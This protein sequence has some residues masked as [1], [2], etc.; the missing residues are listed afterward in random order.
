MNMSQVA[1]LSGEPI[2]EFWCIATT[3]GMGS[4]S[5]FEYGVANYLRQVSS[6]TSWIGAMSMTPK[7]SRSNV[8]S[9][10]PTSPHSFR[11]TLDTWFHAKLLWQR[12]AVCKIH[13][14]IWQNDG[15]WI[16]SLQTWTCH[17]WQNMLGICRISWPHEAFPRLRRRR[18]RSLLWSLQNTVG[19]APLRADT[20]LC[21]RTASLKCFR[22][23]QSKW[24]RGRHRWQWRFP[25]S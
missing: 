14:Q 4:G 8:E 16:G 15:I 18:P 10:A 1:T 9:A 7:A 23:P 22:L 11:E 6:A 5:E 12:W 3:V 25:G 17:V 24:H 2:I 19:P 13:P 21:T 20:K